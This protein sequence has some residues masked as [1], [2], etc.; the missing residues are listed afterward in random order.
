MYFSYPK[1][2]HIP[3]IPKELAHERYIPKELAHERHGLKE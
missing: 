3:H 1:P 2:K